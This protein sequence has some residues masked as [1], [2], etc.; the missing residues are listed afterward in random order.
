MTILFAGAGWRSIHRGSAMA[1]LC[2]LAVGMAGCE[3][4]SGILGQTATP[5]TQLVPSTPAKALARIGIAPVIGAPDGVAKRLT[6]DFS[7]A[8][9]Q[10]NIRVTAPQ[11]TPDYTLRG[12]VVAARDKAGVKVSYIW[13]V[14]DPAGRRANRI[15]G[16]EIIAGAP[17]GDAWAAVTPATSQSIAQKSAES[18]ATWLVAQAPNAAA[19]AA[20]GQTPTGVG[21]SAG[22]A[23]GALPQ[24]DAQKTANASGVTTAP[25]VAVVPS[26]SG[27]PGDGNAMLARALQAELGKNG[28]NGTPVDA[29]AYRVE[30]VVKLGAAADGKQPVQIDW[31]VK[32]PQG[33]R[34]GT[35][36]QKNEVAAGSLDASWGKTADAA[37]AAAAQGI[38]KLL[39]RN[40]AS[41]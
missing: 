33:K 2:G 14:T 3:T 29:T 34:L 9:A 31:N 40:T 10:K 15:T 41:N 13:D 26:L 17:A 12:Y 22:T 1:L 8:V 18:L 16:E 19:I 20:V 30:G 23:V 4:G 37:A 39:P 6:Q 21:A 27:A 25:L 5:E 38:L 24:S 35:V 7:T 11:E 36:T 28:V 32:D